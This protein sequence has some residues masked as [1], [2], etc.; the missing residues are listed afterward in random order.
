[1]QD[2]GCKMQDAGWRFAPMRDARCRMQD[3]AARRCKMMALRADARYG[4]SRRSRMRDA[5][6]RMKEDRFVLL[7]SFYGIWVAID[8]LSNVRKRK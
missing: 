7:F 1:M 4:A 3:G 6:C 8:C 2:K 5:R